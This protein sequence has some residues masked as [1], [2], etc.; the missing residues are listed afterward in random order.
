MTKMHLLVAS[1]LWASTI[2]CKAGDTKCLVTSHTSFE[3]SS[4]PD[5]THQDESCSNSSNN[6]NIN[7]S[8]SNSNNS[9]CVVISAGE[10]DVPETNSTDLTCSGSQCSSCWKYC[11]SVSQ[12]Y[13]CQ[14]VNVSGDSHCY[15]FEQPSVCSVS[16]FCQVNQC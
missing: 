12:P 10:S 5:I 8:N 11:A 14:V 15:C 7:I 1:A 4:M 6:I 2:A 16:G 13:Y 3:S 9:K